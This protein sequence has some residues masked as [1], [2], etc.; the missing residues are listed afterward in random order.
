MMGRVNQKAIKNC[1][2]PQ[3]DRE[4]TLSEI[5]IITRAAPARA[6][7]LVE[8]GALGRG[9]GCRHHDLHG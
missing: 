4:Y 1:L 6:L 3:L 2:L 8:Q 7:G 5:A 9:R